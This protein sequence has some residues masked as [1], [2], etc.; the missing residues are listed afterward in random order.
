MNAG[1]R[2]FSVSGNKHEHIWTKIGYDQIW[3]SRT[4]KLIGITIDDEQKFYEYITIVKRSKRI[5]L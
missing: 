5:L 4:I 3:K 1:K 2:R